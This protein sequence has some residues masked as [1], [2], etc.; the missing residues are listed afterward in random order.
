MMRTLWQ[1]GSDE[2]VLRVWREA[3]TASRGRCRYPLMNGFA[4]QDVHLLGRL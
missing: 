2:I 1:A 4:L 3:A